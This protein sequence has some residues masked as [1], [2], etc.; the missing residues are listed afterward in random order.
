MTWPRAFEKRHN[1]TLAHGHKFVASRGKHTRAS[2]KL[3][4]PGFYEFAV[5][6]F[7]PREGKYICI[8]AGEHGEGGK[9]NYDLFSEKQITS[10]AA[11]TE[12]PPV[13][14]ATVFRHLPTCDERGQPVV[15]E[16]PG[17][18][19][20][21]HQ[22][23]VTPAVWPVR[24]N[25]TLHLKIQRGHTFINPYTI[26]RNGKDEFRGDQEYAV[27]GYNGREEKYIC[28]D[29]ADHHDATG[30]YSFHHFTEKQILA[31]RPSSM[32]PPDVLFARILRP[33]P[34]C[35][36]RG[37]VVA[38]K[39]QHSAPRSSAF[40]N[41]PS[42]QVP[43]PH[44]RLSLSSDT[45]SA[46]SSQGMAPESAAD[47][48][49]ASDFVAHYDE[50]PKT[51]KL[52]F[53]LKLDRGLRFTYEQQTTKAAIS[54]NRYGWLV[55]E[56]GKKGEEAVPGFYE[57]IV[58]GFDP[59]ESKYL[60]FEA[61]NNRSLAVRLHE[62]EIRNSLSTPR[63]PTV[64]F[65]AGF[66]PLPDCDPRTLII[67][68]FQRPAHHED[69]T[70]P[71]PKPS[72]LLAQSPRPRVSADMNT[73]DKG[74]EKS[75]ES[76]NAA[77]ESPKAFPVSAPPALDV[78]DYCLA[79]E[80]VR[81]VR[82]ATALRYAGYPP[83]D[84]ATRSRYG[85]KHERGL[86][87]TATQHRD[88]AKVE[89]NFDNWLVKKWG[90]PGEKAAPGIY[91]YVIAGYNG[92]LDRYLCFEAM[93]CRTPVVEFTAA[94]IEEALHKNY[95]EHNSFKGKYPVLSANEQNLEGSCSSRGELFGFRRS[96][97]KLIG[98][99]PQRQDLDQLPPAPRDRF[100]IVVNGTVQHARKEEVKPHW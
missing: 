10:A 7:S 26:R 29:A 51:S 30:S 100:Q 37:L 54:T 72:Q 83:W 43:G 23:P 53:D 33:L 46:R 65:R 11:T 28:I 9:Y 81:T 6:G 66:P 71:Y 94:E 17:G 19:T 62:D 87:F 60:C 95:Q 47:T 25:K 1:L 48:L 24:L 85:L 31:A 57:Y 34:D 68:G 49:C 39:E 8:E 14:F 78:R 61:G 98:Q 35:D 45:P 16:V 73:P 84:H 50:W 27:V 15:S 97:L 3:D 74:R 13:R 93:D 70:N 69:P 38:S 52:L 21:I 82:D 75:R 58:A 79:P 40:L 32:K 5:V 36:D 18:E 90:I 4:A 22:K 56:W 44:G 91:E 67:R 77:H 88:T 42:T 63:I 59:R 99:S 2:G 86:C 89:K 80:N 20:A 96:V 92:R 55:K 41:P 12:E 76:T 64:C